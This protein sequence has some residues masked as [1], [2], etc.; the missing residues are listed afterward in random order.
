MRKLFG[1]LALLLA[2]LLVV[3]VLVGCGGDEDVENE[4]MPVSFVSADPPSGCAI[5]ANASITLTFDG[6]PE[7]VR[8]SPGT[9]ILSGKTVV[10]TGPFTPGPLSVAVTWA[11]GS[12][13]LTYTPSK[14]CM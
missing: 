6:E 2:G 5:S 12:T 13:T 10:V 7:D 1:T 4:K 8:V 11:D 9:A 3:F 14:P